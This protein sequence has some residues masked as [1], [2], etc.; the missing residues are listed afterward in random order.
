M[1]K[2][3]MIFNNLIKDYKAN[4]SKEVIDYINNNSCVFNL[5]IIDTM[6]NEVLS[7]YQGKN[8][9]FDLFLEYRLIINAIIKNQNFNVIYNPKSKINSLF[10]MV[11]ILALIFGPD[12]DKFLS[13]CADVVVGVVE[14]NKKG[15]KIKH[16]A[17][18]DEYSIDDL[19]YI[20]KI[21]PLNFYKVSDYYQI[22][23]RSLFTYIVHLSSEY[24]CKYNIFLKKIVKDNLREIKNERVVT[25]V[26]DGVE[27]YYKTNQDTFILEEVQLD[28]NGELRFG[29]VV[30]DVYFPVDNIMGLVLT[31]TY[32]SNYLYNKERR[33][34]TDEVVKY[35][36]NGWNVSEFSNN[37]KDMNRTKYIIVFACFERLQFLFVGSEKKKLNEIEELNLYYRP[38]I[39]YLIKNVDLNSFYFHN[40]GLNFSILYYLSILKGLENNILNFLI[41]E[42]IEAPINLVKVNVYGVLKICFAFDNIYKIGEPVLYLSGNEYLIGFIHEVFTLPFNRLTGIIEYCG[43]S[44]IVPI[45]NL[46][47]IVDK[48]SS[49]DD[50]VILVKIYDGKDSH[51]VIASEEIPFI[52]QSVEYL[53]KPAIVV[54]EPSAVERENL[55]INNYQKLH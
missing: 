33:Y 41:D 2:E 55:D 48:R 42:N 3:E 51:I 32:R 6:V 54:A 14:V 39:N 21:H 20:G 46:K 40:N 36:L 26:V 52:G 4:N 50:K 38:F 17:F 12:I 9:N 5:E 49:F 27:G 43:Y 13:E 18:N 10:E 7:L 37:L 35:L 15:L 23:L 8:E 45:L 25:V 31:R 34:L 19:V 1:K 16:F 53:G 24:V 44:S 30:G 47:E 29:H 22:K 28:I 11:R